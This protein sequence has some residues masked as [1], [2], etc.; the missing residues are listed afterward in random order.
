MKVEKYPS[1][2]QVLRD[3]KYLGREKDGGSDFFGSE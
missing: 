2:S 3:S 1:P